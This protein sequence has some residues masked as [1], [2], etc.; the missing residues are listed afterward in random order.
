MAFRSPVVLGFLAVSMCLVACGDDDD[1]SAGNGAN[2]GGSAGASGAAAG[3]GGSGA[4][5]A[6]GGASGQSGSAGN[7]ANG[8]S[9]G[10]SGNSGNSGNGG[11]GNS[12]GTGGTAGASGSGGVSGN[13]GSAGNSGNSGNAGSGGNSGTAGNAGSAGVAGTG[14]GESCLGSTLLD[15][16]GKNGLMIGFS[17]EDTTAD[18]ASFDGRYLYLAGGVFD[19]TSACDSC[20]SCTA[21]GQAC[22]NANGCAW[23]GCWQWDQIPPGQYVRDHIDGAISRNQIPMITYY[24]L[25]HTSGGAETPEAEMASAADVTLMTRLLADWKFLAQTVG[26]DMALLHFEP[27]FWGYAMHVNQNPHS[28]PAAV[29]SAAPSDCAGIENTIAGLGQCVIKIVHDNA[30]NAKVGLHASGWATGFDALGNSD[31]GLDV[32]SEAQKLGDFLLAAGAADGDYI[33]AD[34]S[35]RDAEYYESLGQNRWWDDTNTTLPNF[36][37]AFSWSKALAERLGKPVIW[38]QIPVG[39]MSLP[40]GNN[41]WK[42]NRLDYLFDHPAEV[43]ASHGVGLFFGAGQGDQTTAES[44][45]GHLISRTN[46]FASQGGQAV[47]Q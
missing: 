17:G 15:S 21:A 11:T 30:P 8:G 32:V 12:A 44:D 38:W 13:S 14:G 6:S 1:S 27:D 24:E 5:G 34:M 22:D 7:G 2:Q 19:G 4:V 33:V 40:G 35:D 47:C 31:S 39:N 16:L 36:T 43:T 10:T 25:L 9:G 41:Q 23:W 45:G 46:N 42:D 26:Q 28:I 3:S 29:A 20:L 18:A 37:Q